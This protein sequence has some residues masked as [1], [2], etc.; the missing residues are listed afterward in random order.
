[1]V[2]SNIPWSIFAH[3]Y[4]VSAP[5]CPDWVRTGLAR[6]NPAWA[7]AGLA[8]WARIQL[9]R[10]QLANLGQNLGHLAQI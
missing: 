7:T 5:G 6:S 2:M 8:I 3:A 1:M 10:I 4:P 9:A